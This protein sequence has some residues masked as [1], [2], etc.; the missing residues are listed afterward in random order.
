[1]NDWNDILFKCINE[2]ILTSENDI[3]NGISISPK[4][5]F[6]IIKIWFKYDNYETKYKGLFHEFNTSFKLTNT[7][8]KK[9]AF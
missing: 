7:L 5:E 2:S 3:I 4:K 6:N 8:Y 9:H 1:M